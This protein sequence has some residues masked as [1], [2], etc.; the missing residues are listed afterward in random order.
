MI[1]KIPKKYLKKRYFLLLLLGIIYYFI[2]PKKLFDVPYATVVLSKE[3]QL[4]GA[5]I[6][7]DG[8]WRFPERKTVPEKFKHC[9]LEFEDAYFYYHP[10]FNPISIVKSLYLNLKSGQTKRGGSTLTQQVIRLHR[11][12]KKRTYLEKLYELILSTRLEFRHSKDEILALYTSYAPYGGN[13]VGLDMAAWRYF[14]QKPENLSWSETATLAV[15]PNAPSLIYPGKN[16]KRLLKKRNRLLKKLFK[17]KIIDSLTYELAILE[18]LPQST[19]R[20]PQVSPHFVEK[21]HQTNSQQKVKTTI[22]F[23]LQKNINS[24]VK[25]HYNQLSQ[26]KIYN[27]AVLVLDVETRNIL[28][29][30]GNSPTTKRHQ[31]DVD[32][33]SK[34]RSTGSILKPILYAG[35][36]DDGSILPKSLLADIPVQYKNYKPSNFHKDYDGAVAADEALAR[37]LNIPAVV[38]LRKYGLQKF[39]DDLKK[40]NFTTIQKHPDH[41]GLSLILGGAESNL[42]DLTRTYAGFAGTINHFVENESSYFSK[43]FSEPNYIFNKKVDF[44][45]KTNEKPIFDAGAM[46]LTFKAL[47]NVERPEGFENWNNYTSAEK[48]A[49]KTG[50]SFGFRDAWAIGTTKKYT[51]GVWVGNADGEGRPGLVGVKAAAPI[52]FSIFDI[53]PNS[54]WFSI[55]YDNLHEIEL[56][57]KSGDL[58]TANCDEKTLSLIPKAGLET[59]PC[60]YHKR[61]HLD[62]TEQFQVNSS[63]E[64][65]TQ[66]VHKNYFVLPP[67]MEYY[68]KKKN[69]FYKTLP[70]FRIDCNSENQQIMEF[71]YP[72]DVSTIYIPKDFNGEKSEVILKAA[73]KESNATLFWY[74]NDK[75]IGQTETIHQISLQPDTGFY[76]ITIVDTY[77]NKISKNV[78]IE[79]S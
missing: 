43:E 63:C 17:E 76:K 40:L 39:Y 30:V 7:K 72:K 48:V 13:V 70:K 6:A 66:I 71:I 4:L 54:D 52:L 68:Y 23:Q 36:L 26:N 59:F 12:G 51:I 34:P 45:K 16:Q 5:K 18:E 11:K 64:P 46:Y 29:Y 62:K 74:L 73:H 22:D 58:A 25:R 41:Y 56:C 77:G 47:N 67:L 61:V 28:A 75:Y 9:I 55:P 69:V 1:Q 3:N 57:S 49:W 8:Q 37:S 42:W 38:S 27:I 79:N 32:I 14:G 60:K 21:V 10:G 78:K 50:T 2:L 31:K 19:H 44:G 24:I 65:L 15:L 33:I 53:L 20:L 35:M